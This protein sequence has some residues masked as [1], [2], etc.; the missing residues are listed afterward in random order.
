MPVSRPPLGPKTTGPICPVC[1]APTQ[2]LAARHW[3]FW[4]C[5]TCQTISLDP[6]LEDPRRHFDAGYYLASYVPDKDRYIGHLKGLLG[7]LLRIGTTVDIGC[8]V[9][10]ALIAAAELGN[11]GVG[12]DQSGAA[13]QFTKD[14]GM[15]VAQ[16][17]ASVVPLQG[18]CASNVLLL[19]L[20]A[21][22]DDPS[23]VIEEASRLLRPGGHLIV[24][25]PRRPTAVYHIAKLVPSRVAT[26]LLHA[27]SY[28]HLISKKGLEMLAQQSGL[29]VTSLSPCSEAM[30]PLDRILRVHRRTR[31]VVLGVLAIELFL[32]APSWLM[33]ATPREIPT[34]KPP[35][36]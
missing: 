25:S 2:R 6:E 18:K 13:C 32:G 3:V 36:V 26:A 29:Q 22:V 27:P 11:Q 24:K 19:E 1:R 17:D 9:G 4:R 7:P 21:H 14:H 23:A 5:T 10:V 16:A 31:L 28:R 12:L 8:G 20:L 33:V 35:P 15:A 30:S 34:G